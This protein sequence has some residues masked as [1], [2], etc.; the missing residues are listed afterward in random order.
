MFSN[1]K[2][3]ENEV[4]LVFSIFAQRPIYGHFVNLQVF[5]FDDTYLK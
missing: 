2:V 5:P 1:L 4:V 3:K